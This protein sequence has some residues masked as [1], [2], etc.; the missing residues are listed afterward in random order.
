[1]RHELAVLGV[2][3]TCLRSGT[4]RRHAL[5]V[6]HTPA[7][8]VGSAAVVA[9]PRRETNVISRTSKFP[10]TIPTQAKGKGILALKEA[11]VL[12]FVIAPFTSPFT[13]HALFY[14]LALSRAFVTAL[15]PGRSRQMSVATRRALPP[16]TTLGA[17][18][19]KPKT[20]T[21]G[22]GTSFL[23]SLIHSTP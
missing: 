20:P 19:P 6:V 12:G 13:F 16:T 1:M 14:G 11:R 7:D 5:G 10:G 22:Q 2:L 23:S 9:L 18:Y 4:W 21:P 17:Q 15:V 3:G 8:A